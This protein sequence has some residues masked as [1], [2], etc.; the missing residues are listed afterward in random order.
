MDELGALDVKV[1]V[2]RCDVADLSQVKSLVSRCRDTLPP[3]RGVIHGAMA[4]RDALFDRISHKDWSL[5]IK[6]RMQGAWNLHDALSNSKLDFFVMLASVSGIIGNAGQSAYAASNTFL[7]SFAAYRNRLGLPASTIDIGVVES[8]GYAAENME[9]K[10]EIAAAAHDRLSEAEL[11]AVIKAAITKPIPACTFQQTVTGLKL[12]PG[13]KI[14]G[15]ATD[16]K[17]AHVLH[18]HQAMAAIVEQSGDNA[19]TTRQLLKQAD[20]LQSVIQVAW[21]AVAQRLSSLLMISAEEVDVKKPVVAYGLDSLAAVELRNWITND[22]E[23]NVPL[24][25]LMNSSS[26]EH[27]SGKIVS[28]SRLVDKTLLSS[29]ADGEAAADEK[30]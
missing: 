27:L 20:T 28:K 11:L 19:N 24:I 3:I 15:W 14:P 23:A 18:D 17:F 22:L 16:P 9:R 13:K 5:N 26:I 6:P 29:E 30:N 4:L 7:D 21:K 1:F 10:P 2:D 8:V 25:E 12:Q